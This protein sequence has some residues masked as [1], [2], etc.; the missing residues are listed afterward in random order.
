MMIAG[1]FWIPLAPIVLIAFACRLLVRLKR[2]SEGE[3]RPLPAQAAPAP[4]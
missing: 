4:A 3:V 1:F 2:G